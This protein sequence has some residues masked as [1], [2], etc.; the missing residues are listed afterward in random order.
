MFR[1]AQTGGV[2]V[3]KEKVWSLAYA[4][5]LVI[6]AKKK[7]EMRTMIKSFEKYVEKRH[8]N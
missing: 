5:D 7:E 3:D 4:D 6:V 2:V 1:K 8:W